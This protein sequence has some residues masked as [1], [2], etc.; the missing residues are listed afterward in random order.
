MGA[1][2]PADLCTRFLRLQRRRVQL[3]ELVMRQDPAAPRARSYLLAARLLLA[4]LALRRETRR[5]QALISK[6]EG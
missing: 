6:G 5:T 1:M 3:T 2:T 4:Y